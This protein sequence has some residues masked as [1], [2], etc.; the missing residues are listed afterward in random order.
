MAGQLSDGLNAL[1]ASQVTGA[2]SE[3]VSP[4]KPTLPSV[5]GATPGA[6]LNIGKGAGQNHFELGVG[7]SGDKT[8]TTKSQAQL[9]AGW[10]EAPYLYTVGLDA[11]FGVR[12]NGPTTPGSK[13]PRSE[14]RELDAAGAKYAFD[15]SKGDHWLTA[16]SRPIHLPP[17][18]PSVVV[19][20]LHDDTDDLIEL[21]VQPRA[22]YATTGK[23]EVV[24]RIRGTSVGLPKLVAD[25]QL[26]AELSW[27]IR[28]G[29]FGWEVYLGDLAVPVLTS[30]QAG[31]PKLGTSGKVCYFKVG[32]YL[33]TNTSVESDPTE[34]GL[35][36]VRA[37]RHWHTGWP[38]PQ[39]A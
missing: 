27:K 1:A 26:G 32:A 15:A 31:R 4:A 35:V 17:V 20:Q 21:A 13:N 10:T 9:A 2:P 11:V 38:A 25:Y 36:A 8:I 33:Q 14:L 12:V 24:C 39:A 28:V 34:Y 22:D 6:I 5:I 37:L 23:L 19:G 7:R 3:T 29:A 18:K 16:R 30:L